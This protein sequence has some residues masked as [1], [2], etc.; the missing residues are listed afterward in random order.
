MMLSEDESGEGSEYEEVR[1]NEVY[2]RY[3]SLLGACV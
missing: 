1:T 2:V 3:V